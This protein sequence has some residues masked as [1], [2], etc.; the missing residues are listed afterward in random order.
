MA[1]DHAS[2]D[3]SEADLG[4]LYKFLLAWDVRDEHPL[5]GLTCFFDFGCTSHRIPPIPRVPTFTKSVSEV[6]KGDWQA[7]GD[8]MWLF[9]PPT[10]DR[11]KMMTEQLRRLLEDDE[12]SDE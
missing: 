3:V 7:V 11:Q 2:I 10:A 1:T 12:A 8:S 6:L 4:D 5:E 9:L